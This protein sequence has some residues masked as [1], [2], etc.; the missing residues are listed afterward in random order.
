MKY[1]QRLLRH[2]KV[3][4][5]WKQHEE[6]VE[7]RSRQGQPPPEMSEELCQGLAA[8]LD[9]LKQIMLEAQAHAEVREELE[10]FGI[11]V[12]V[13]D[14]QLKIRWEGKRHLDGRS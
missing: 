13:E 12:Y 8:Y 7:A 9:D 4:E 1:V 5:L 14:N 11:C 10:Q 3:L 6:S 2:E